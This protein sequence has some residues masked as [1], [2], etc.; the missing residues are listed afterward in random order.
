MCLD[1]PPA[2]LQ[3]GVLSLENFATDDEVFWKLD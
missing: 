1:V 3:G 2:A